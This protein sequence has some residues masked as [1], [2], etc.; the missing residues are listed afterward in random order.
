MLIFDQLKKDDPRLRVVA[1]IVLAGLG[2]L[3]AGLWWVQIVS[4]GEYQAHL[5]M[6]SF[7]TVRMPAVRGKI[8]DR[9]GMVLAEN[10]P[11]YHISMYLEDLKKSFDAACNQEIEHARQGLKTQAAAQQTRRGRKLTREERKQFLLTTKQKELLRQKARYLVAS[12]V[13]AQIG[14]VLRLPFTASLNPT[15]FQRHYEESLALPL[16]IFTNLTP[17]QIALFAE[18]CSSPMGVDL[19]MQSV[20]SYPHRTTA[21]H[22]IGSVRSDNRSIEGEDAFFSYR[23]PDYCGQLGIEAGYDR[24]LHGKAGVKSVV[25][26]NVGYRQTE[27]IWQPAE[28]GTNVVLTIDLKLQQKVE[29]DLQIYGP[30]T[31]GAAVV[32]DVQTGDILA[33]ASSPT[34]DPND[35]VEGFAPGELSRRNDPILRP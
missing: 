9:T 31:R 25:V 30:N 26:N 2:V 16:P 8:L 35:S 15:N 4:A 3:A 28:P 20:R 27:N 19:E 7:R 12:N 1:L 18:Q 17:A 33:L 34:I 14:Q 11:V 23:L 10:R 22:V 29:R 5:E 24:E 21:A 13:V 32:L 6:Q